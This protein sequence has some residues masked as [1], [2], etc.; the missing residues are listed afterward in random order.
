MLD[1]VIDNYVYRYL[2][3]RKIL[4]GGIIIIIFVL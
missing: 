4:W 1:I 2:I 3:V